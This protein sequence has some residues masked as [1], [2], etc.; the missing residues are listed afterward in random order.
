MHTNKLVSSAWW[1]AYDCI[2]SYTCMY[3]YPPI[4]IYLYIY[5]YTHVHVCSHI[6]IILLHRLPVVLV[7]RYTIALVCAHFYMSRMLIHTFV[8]MICIDYCLHWPSM[9]HRRHKS[10][11]V[12]ACRWS[13]PVLE[14]PFWKFGGSF[15]DTRQLPVEHVADQ[16]AKVAYRKCPILVINIADRRCRGHFMLSLKCREGLL[17]SVFRFNIY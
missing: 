5:I 4:S 17:S 14:I 7:D 1:G 15:D 13:F 12:Q 3:I 9:I 2:C 11:C 10:T 6:F 16:P 8:P